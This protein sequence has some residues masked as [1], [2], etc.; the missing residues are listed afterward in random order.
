MRASVCV[1]TAL[2]TWAS[3]LLAVVLLCGV[4]TGCRG[5]DGDSRNDPA[6]PDVGVS[7]TGDQTGNSNRPAAASTA[8]AD[9]EGLARLINDI[10][11]L[12]CNEHDDNSA[13]RVY[14]YEHGLQGLQENARKLSMYTDDTM[15]RSLLQSD[16]IE[17]INSLIAIAEEADGDGQ[18]LHQVKPGITPTLEELQQLKV[19]AQK[20]LGI[21]ELPSDDE[22]FSAT[23]E[24]QI[25]DQ[26]RDAVQTELEGVNR[27]VGSVENKLA[28]IDDLEKNAKYAADSM[29][30][31]KAMSVAALLVSVICCVLLILALVHISAV[32]RQVEYLTEQTSKEAK[33]MNVG[34]PRPKANDNREYMDSINGLKN[35]MA[36]IETALNEVRSNSIPQRNY[37]TEHTFGGT[38][39]RTG[40]EISFAADG[41]AARLRAARSPADFSGKRGFGV[42]EYHIWPDPWPLN[43]I[44][45]VGR[46]LGEIS[47]N[48]L[49]F[50]R[51]SRFFDVDPKTPQN[52]RSYQITLLDYALVRKSGGFYELVNKGKLRARG[53]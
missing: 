43:E 20:L 5:D 37:N 50:G 48:D 21:T 46:E 8:F 19:D 40:P 23:Q 52:Y 16:I 29:G 1:R 30:V 26:V 36:G 38:E 7:N 12:K 51:V 6:N 17:K 49:Y 28:G 27:R 31:V 4:M 15:V 41:N 34:V 33:N 3:L 25:Q 18:V 2:R 45:A 14:R 24:H 11:K 44:P 53:I 22:R 9:Q 10:S 13:T 47:K 35:R 32:R 39:S 42:D